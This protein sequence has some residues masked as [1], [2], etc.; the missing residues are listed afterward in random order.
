LEAA[1]AHGSNVASKKKKA[2]SNGASNGRR[3]PRE[4]IPPRILA[5][6][7]LRRA[8]D[9]WRALMHEGD[10]FAG[11]V[12]TILTALDVA[13][14]ARDSDALHASVLWARRYLDK[15]IG[16][17]PY[18]KRTVAAKRFVDLAS[19][20]LDAARG[21]KKSDPWAPLRTEK[22]AK[23]MALQLG[24][25]LWESVPSGL[26]PK[27]PEE[28]FVSFLLK[29]ATQIQT[30]AR[31]DKLDG[32]GLAAAALRGWGLSDRQAQDALTPDD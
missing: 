26:V 9:S 32:K 12:V 21:T 16:T 30:V 27:P 14:D 31:R 2:Q 1:R 29:I 7:E 11:H 6:H 4:A 18:P 10:Q 28:N 17:H 13:A 24:M 25:A 23:A 20:L 15:K 8:I 19:G 3:L 5:A 22:I